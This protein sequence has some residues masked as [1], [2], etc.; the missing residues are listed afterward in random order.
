M[1]VNP[2]G[3]VFFPLLKKERKKKQKEQNIAWTTIVCIR[4]LQFSLEKAPEDSELPF[5]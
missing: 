5:S 4:H 3:G 1:H 2:F